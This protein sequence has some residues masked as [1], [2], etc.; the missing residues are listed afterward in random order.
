M[1]ESGRRARRVGIVGTSP[2]G[3][4]YASALLG[5][6][7][8]AE[9]VLIDDNSASARSAVQDLARAA[10]RA[11]HTRLWAG[12]YDDCA[13]AVLTVLATSAPPRDAENRLS[14]AGE[15]GA[16]FRR[17]VSRVGQV[18]PH[19]L[20]L[21]AT[22]PVDVLTYAAW[23]LSGLPGRQVIGSG[24]MPET[25]RFRALLGA[26]CGV[27]PRAVRAYMVG[28]H[29]AGALPLWSSAT[30]GGLALARYCV[31][32]GIPYDEQV[33]AEIAGRTH[34]G[35]E[36]SDVTRDAMAASLLRMSEVILRNQCAVLAVSSLIE[37]DGHNDGI[38]GV[39]L[40]LPTV[41]DRSGVARVP[42]LT[43]TSEERER[44]RHAAGILRV[45]VTGL[46][47][48]ERG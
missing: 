33:Q 26:H 35:A 15:T 21:V 40:S 24:T 22:E 13:E 47:L 18:N 23:R 4:A 39:C 6:G 3:A 29:G 41:V 45:A 19:G 36:G 10:L 44:V 9:V 25:A 34:T 16:V 37:D 2:V 32:Q 30:I 12:G 42:R 38:A 20:L 14:L 27:D 48:G 1:E 7:L 5:S 11:P 8:A 46:S 31:A 43:L 28:K 17:I